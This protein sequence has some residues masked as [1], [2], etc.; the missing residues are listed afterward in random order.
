MRHCE[1]YLGRIACIV[2][3]C[4]LLL[5]TAWRGLSVHVLVAI[6]SPAKVAQGIEIPFMGG[7]LMWAH[8]NMLPAIYGPTCVASAMRKSLPLL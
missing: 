7:R 3:E 5:Q 8:R 4:G 2:G 6:T 1:K